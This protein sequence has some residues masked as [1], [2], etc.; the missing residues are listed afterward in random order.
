MQKIVPQKR[1]TGQKRKIRHFYKKNQR[2]T[3]WEKQQ[4]KVRKC[5]VGELENKTVESFY[6]VIVKKIS[7]KH[8]KH[9]MF[10]L[11]YYTENM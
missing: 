1:R 6:D 3:G 11:I 2:K 8:V 4:Q 10:K 7:N 9:D 5:V